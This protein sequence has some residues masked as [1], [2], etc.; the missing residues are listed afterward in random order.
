[1]DRS[2]A[3]SPSYDSPCD[4]RVEAVEETRFVWSNAHISGCRIT[5]PYLTLAYASAICM[6]TRTDH[7]QRSGRPVIEPLQVFPRL[8]LDTSDGDEVG[9]EADQGTSNVTVQHGPCCV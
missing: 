6:C 4:P 5:S 2:C 1:M 7:Q 3:H 8:F 9:A